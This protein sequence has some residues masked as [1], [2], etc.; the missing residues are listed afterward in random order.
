M[1]IAFELEITFSVG[2]VSI[3]TPP[4]LLTGFRVET[5]VFLLFPSSFLFAFDQPTTVSSQRDQQTER[6]ETRVSRGETHIA[7]HL[8]GGW[9]VSHREA[10]YPRNGG[11]RAETAKRLPLGRRKRNNNNNNEGPCLG[12]DAQDA[13]DAQEAS[14][15]HSQLNDLIPE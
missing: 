12:P 4:L 8:V 7:T 13:Q 14:I 1:V 11:E 2:Q 15:S 5:G 6:K 10:S 3:F 9:K